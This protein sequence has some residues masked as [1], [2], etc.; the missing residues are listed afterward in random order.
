MSTGSF[1]AYVPEGVILQIFDPIFDAEGNEIPFNTIW[2]PGFVAD[3]V[4]ITGVS[5][6]PLVGWTYDGANFAAPLPPPG[7][8]PAEILAANTAT[9]NQYLAAATLAIGPLQDAVDIGEATDDD[10]AMLTKWKQFRVA[11]NRVVLTAQNPTWPT[12]PQPGY[13]AAITS[14]VSL[15]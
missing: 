5:P 8:T 7:P 13:G 10:V 9:R 15:S 6:T 1:H 4:D 14:P 2:S 12:P 3:C 11:V